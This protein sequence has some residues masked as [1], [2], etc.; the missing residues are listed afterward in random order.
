MKWLISFITIILL[1]TPFSSAAIVQGEIYDFSLD[2]VTNIII[3]VNS[4]PIQKQVVKNGSYSF[5]LPNGDYE[6][7]V[8]S[9]NGSILGHENL[10][11]INDGNYKLDIILF[12]ESDTNE[13]EV[14]LESDFQEDLNENN[15]SWIWA[16]LIIVLLL[17]IFLIF[18]FRKNRVVK[19]N[20]FENDELV[21]KVLEFIK[22][23]KYRLI[24]TFLFSFAKFT[25]SNLNILYIDKSLV[26]KP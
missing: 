19:S 24:T 12:P 22:N 7:F 23:E 20:N 3:E 9:L 25:I 26:F 16:I 6:L 21:N 8:F 2:Y 17:I 4:S 14:D 1:I 18:N 13:E 5:E 10:I 15:Y 11:I